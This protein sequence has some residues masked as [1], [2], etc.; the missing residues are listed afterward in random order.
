[1]DAGVSDYELG[2]IVC[3]AYA[4]RMQ[5]VDRRRQINAYEKFGKV[6]RLNLEVTYIYGKAGISKTRRVMDEYGD[7]NVYRITRL[8]RQ[9]I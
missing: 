9:P 2:N 8:R 3:K 1:M 6:R 5:F 7:E 4:R